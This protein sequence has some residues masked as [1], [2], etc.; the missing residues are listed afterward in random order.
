VRHGWAP[1]TVVP[2]TT[3]AG[4]EFSTSVVD[5]RGRVTSAVGSSA[6]NHRVWYLHPD[7][8]WARGRITAV[9]WGPSTWTE[10]PNRPQIGFVFGAQRIRR[11]HWVAL[12][13]WYNIF[14]SA[15]PSGLLVNGWEIDGTNVTL[16]NGGGAGGLGNVNRQG[17]VLRAERLRFLGAELSVMRV[18]PPWAAIIADGTP[19]TVSDM[20]DPDY[21]VVST[22]VAASPGDVNIMTALPAAPDNPVDRIAG[23]LVAPAVPHN[24]CP[25]VVAAERVGHAS[26]RVTQW[27]YGS[28]RADSGDQRS[29]TVTVTQGSMTAFP[30]G[31]PGLHGIVVGHAHSGSYAE[32]GDLLFEQL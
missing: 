28:P 2:A 1:F 24:V 6:P 31:G 26:I 12:V 19:I 27:A 23:G 17:V 11:D 7:T 5:G 20:A 21:D 32:I 29:T 25:Y 15:D 30:T 10:T 18:A 22:V 16:G 8:K 9:W 4:Q 14:A 13:V 3:E